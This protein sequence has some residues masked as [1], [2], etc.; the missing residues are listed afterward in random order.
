MFVYLILYMKSILA[1]F[2]KNLNNVKLYRSLDASTLNL[3][4]EMKMERIF[5]HE[6]TFFF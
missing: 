6:T 3:D 5:V 4:H 2:V 1:P